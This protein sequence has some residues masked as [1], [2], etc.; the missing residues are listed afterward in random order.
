[1]DINRNNIIAYKSKINKVKNSIENFNA[2]KIIADINK[3]QT[4]IQSNLAEDKID[5]LSK[6]ILD[7][8]LSNLDLKNDKNLKDLI[9][10]YQFPNL[11][12][13]KLDS[14]ESKLD[15]K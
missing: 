8:L 15:N 5:N 4:I 6:N 10:P 12:E 7:I 1:M 2:D 9:I 11:R 3:S 13:S 14:N